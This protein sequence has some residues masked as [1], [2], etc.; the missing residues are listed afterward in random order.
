MRV[1]VRTHI[2][3]LKKFFIQYP[4]SGSNYRITNTIRKANSNVYFPFFP[5][6][7]IKKN[8]LEKEL[9]H[10]NFSFPEE[11]KNVWIE[12]GGGELFQDENILYPLPTDN[13]IIEC[14]V[15][16]NQTA[17]EK[18]FSNKYQIF[19]T[20]LCNYT[21]FEKNT[22]EIVVF[23]ERK[24]NFV[25]QS[26]FKNIIEW[27]ENLWSNHFNLKWIETENPPKEYDPLKYF[28]AE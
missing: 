26:N 18:G 16:H 25:V 11:L 1:G 6:G 9:F 17:T 10:Y 20:N 27:F 3:P 21:A 4:F 13:E 5:F 8:N 24:G 23:V 14:M 19:A 28:L 22:H 7:A 12:Y 15:W 2:S